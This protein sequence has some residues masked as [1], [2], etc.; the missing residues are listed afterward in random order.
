MP[1][2][3]PA[4]PAPEPDGFPTVVTA[5]GP[6]DPDMAFIRLARLADLRRITDQVTAEAIA[7]G[8]LPAGPN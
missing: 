2:P 7:R 6:L 3:K 5:A 1:A 8:D 4:A